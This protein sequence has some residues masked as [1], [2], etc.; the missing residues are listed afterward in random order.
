ME[1]NKPSR[2]AEDR[3][4]WCRPF[5]RLL[6]LARRLLTGL[7]LFGDLAAALSVGVRA[8][9]PFLL[10]G[11]A[12]QLP[13]VGEGEAPGLF[14]E[15]SEEMLR[16]AGY[17]HVLTLTP[18]RRAQGVLRTTPGS[19]IMNLARTESREGDYRWL[20]KVIPTPYVLV[21]LGAPFATL[22]QA[23]E[24]GPI[25][26][27][28]G[29]PRAEQAL[30]L[31]GEGRVVQAND[32]LQAARLLQSGRVVAWYEIDSRAL[33]AWRLAGYDPDVLAIGVPQQVV[34]SYLAANLNLPDGDTVE[35]RLRVAFAEMQADGT[36]EGILAR[37]IGSRRARDI[38]AAVIR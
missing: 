30:A 25:V 15:A 7:F 34:D 20:V 21:S 23:F 26:V 31:G 10:L 17:G 12:H 1:R 33:Y 8:Q 32:P 29:T 18:W 3:L 36:W 14:R 19:L 35:R 5:C 4:F 13:Y 22:Q 24:Q 28:A 2:S 38:A 9:E 6:R 37:Y 16:R 11:D 27:L